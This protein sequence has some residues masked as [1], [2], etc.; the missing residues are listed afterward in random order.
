[1]RN[2]KRISKRIKKIENK[3]LLNFY[4]RFDK[5]A[6]NAESATVSFLAFANGMNIVISKVQDAKEKFIGTAK[7]FSEHQMGIESEGKKNFI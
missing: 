1:M 5:A 7:L 2:K 4:F 6:K 3:K